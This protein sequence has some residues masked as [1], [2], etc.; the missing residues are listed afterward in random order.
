M[1]G[2]IDFSKS[3][4]C[5]E[6]IEEILEKSKNAD[7]R[8]AFRAIKHS[9]SE[10]LKKEDFFPTIMEKNG[11]K[12]PDEKKQKKC[13]VEYFGMSVLDSFD[14]AYNLVQTVPALRNE[15]K[16]YAVGT[17]VDSKGTISEKNAVGHYQYYLFEPNS[18][19][20]N[21]FTDFKYY[22]EDNKNG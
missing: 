14:N 10:N 17:V 3:G 7:G 18:N 5:D 4:I 12:M 15:V 22:E 11:F 20:K 19:T 6:K 21:P 8:S 16:C 1:A 13:R 9:K 2:K